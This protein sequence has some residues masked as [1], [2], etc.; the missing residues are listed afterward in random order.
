MDSKVILNGSGFGSGFGF[1]LFRDKRGVAYKLFN[2]DGSLLDIQVRPLG[3]RDEV[4][5][6][7]I[8]EFKVACIDL[9]L[10]L[11]DAY[12]IVTILWVVIVEAETIAED[13]VVLFSTSSS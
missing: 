8:V 5:A 9:P 7:L 10:G 11:K 13:S 12:T 4:V 3:K 2:G 1:W 6:I